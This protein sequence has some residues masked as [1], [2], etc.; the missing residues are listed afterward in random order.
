MGPGHCLPPPFLTHPG[1]L[2]FGRPDGY[3][4]P[5]KLATAELLTTRRVGRMGT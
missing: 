2:P 3:L 4:P 5:E 1:S